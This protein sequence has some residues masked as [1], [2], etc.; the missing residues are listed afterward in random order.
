MFHSTVF[1]REARV[2]TKAYQTSIE[3]GLVIHARAP[4]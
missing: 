1:T 3:V 4:D 2:K